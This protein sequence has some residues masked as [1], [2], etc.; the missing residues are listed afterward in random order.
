MYNAVWVLNS[1]KLGIVKLTMSLPLVV[2]FLFL[3]IC[4]SIANDQCIQK[5]KNLT[6]PK[7]GTKVYISI[8]DL[9]IINVND[10][11]CTITLNFQLTLQWNEP[12]LTYKFDDKDFFNLP[13]SGFNC[14]WV[15]NVFI[16]GLKSMKTHSLTDK[17]RDFFI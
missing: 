9:Q 15:P 13:K 10:D 16:F 6:E 14:L 7:T 1:F 3:H 8:R 12:R 11:D 17:I 4:C 2:I 5:P